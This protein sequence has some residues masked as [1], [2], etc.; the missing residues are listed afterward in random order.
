M[1]YFMLTLLALVMLMPSRA[2]SSDKKE[3]KSKK[4][5]T[6]VFSVNMDCQGC[7]DGITKELTY[8]KGV[9]DLD[10]SLEKKTVKIEYRTDKTT[11]E[12]LKKAIVD[13]GYEVKEAGCKEA[14]SPCSEE[15]HSHHQG[16]E[17]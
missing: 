16:Q 7:V 1:K 2:N 15:P 8:T 12:L 9:K 6:I 4:V 13:L 11:P 17:H 14:N 3:N 5:E 10:I